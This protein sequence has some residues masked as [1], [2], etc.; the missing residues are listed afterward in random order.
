MV[1]GKIQGNK[2]GIG[3]RI[4][5]FSAYDYQAAR[6]LNLDELRRTCAALGVEMVP[7]LRRRVLPDDMGVDEW[8]TY[9]TQSHS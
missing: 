2:L 6:Y 5:F 8:V 3:T 7:V 9:A 1:G 4:Y